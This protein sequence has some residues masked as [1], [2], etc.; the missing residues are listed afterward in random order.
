MIDN[1][2]FKKVHLNKITFMKKFAFKTSSFLLITA[3]F[4]SAFAFR[5]V[6]TNFS[7]KWKL[8]EGKS[9]LGQFANFATK[10]IE[11]LQTPTTCLL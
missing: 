2:L 10:T 9:E 1:F 6:A 5:P 4:C 7:G 11:T 8:N 3:L